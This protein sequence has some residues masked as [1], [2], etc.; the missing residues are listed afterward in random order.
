V[1][2]DSVLIAEQRNSRLAQ[3]PLINSPFADLGV[4]IA[5]YSHLTL[6]IRQETSLEVSLLGNE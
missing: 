6:I 4:W 3:Q 5:V 2:L 1:V